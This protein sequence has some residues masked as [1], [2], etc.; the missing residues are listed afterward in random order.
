MVL[1]EVARVD[2]KAV[3]A[4]LEDLRARLEAIYL[5]PWKYTDLENDGDTKDI[6][7]NLLQHVIIWNP[8]DA[9][10]RETWAKYGHVAPSNHPRELVSQSP[11]AP[12]AEKVEAEDEVAM[13]VEGK[14]DMSTTKKRKWN[15][16]PS[17]LVISFTREYY[18]CQCCQSSMLTDLQS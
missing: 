14:Q 15:W 4:E 10:G 2:N 12:P 18:E 7:L 3:N 11:G 6:E 9:G 16:Q 13:I 8:W 17:P 1:G 5:K